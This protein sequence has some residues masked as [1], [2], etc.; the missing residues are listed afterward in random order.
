MQPLQTFWKY[1]PGKG[2]MLMPFPSPVALCRARSGPA[3]LLCGGKTVVLIKGLSVVFG[4]ITLLFA[5]LK[6][7]LPSKQKDDTLSSKVIFWGDTETAL[8]EKRS[9]IR[10]VNIGTGKSSNLYF[11]W[12]WVLSLETLLFQKEFSE[13]IIIWWL[14]RREWDQKLVQAL[15][16]GTSVSCKPWLV[17][18]ISLVQVI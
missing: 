17:C 8:L 18:Y 3:W 7:S 16:Q 5:T 6:V 14:P 10:Y 4:S 11:K 2:L 12:P 13:F 1:S 15:V 9:N